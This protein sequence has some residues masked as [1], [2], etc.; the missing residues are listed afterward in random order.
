MGMCHMQ[1]PLKG[2]FNF[3]CKIENMSPDSRGLKKKIARSNSSPRPF[4]SVSGHVSR[5]LEELQPLP[6]SHSL[7]HQRLFLRGQYRLAGPVPG[8][9][10]RRD[11]VQERQ[12]HATRRAVVRRTSS[13]ARI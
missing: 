7:L 13:T 9:R 11:C 2:E 12:H 1:K 5:R 10:T 4:P 6:G 8:W 3:F